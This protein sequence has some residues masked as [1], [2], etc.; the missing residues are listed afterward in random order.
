[1]TTLELGQRRLEAIPTPGHT[2][3]HYV[4]ADL[5]SSTLMAGDHVLPTITPS[6]G[7]TFP[8]PHNPL[9]AFLESLARV[10]ALPDLQ[11]LPA[12]GPVA[13]SSHE[14]V[15]ELLTFHDRRLEMS[16]AAL[17]DT[18]RTAAQVAQDLPWTRR[19]RALG[20]LNSFDAY[21]AVMETMA[22]LDVLASRGTVTRTVS[23]GTNYYAST[24]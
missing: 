18:N 22:H 21:L 10:R 2:P 8:R 15:E 5:A 19:G 6:I 14:R 20:D 17:G 7:F 24:V 11:L 9:G 16:L 12:H 23:R 1:V 13:P 4:F 3:G